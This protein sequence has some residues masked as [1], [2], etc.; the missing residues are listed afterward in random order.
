MTPEEKISINTKIAK[1]FGWHSF[2]IDSNTWFGKPRHMGLHGI[3]NYPMDIRDY[4]GS[5]DG[6]D[7]LTKNLA[8]NG[9]YMEFRFGDDNPGASARIVITR[10][11]KCY[12]G[13]SDSSLYEALAIAVC[14][15]IDD[16]SNKEYLESWK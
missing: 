7:S 13:Y 6:F 15:M 9:I 8:A 4:C 12:R 16:E 14:K 1:L 3:T 10:F 11:P 5:S 2:W